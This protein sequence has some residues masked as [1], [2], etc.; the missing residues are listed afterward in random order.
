VDDWY[1]AADQCIYRQVGA[2]YQRTSPQR[3]KM[4][5]GS[6][7]DRQRFLSMLVD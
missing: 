2:K 5:L 4:A 1:V 3:L 7:E 6:D